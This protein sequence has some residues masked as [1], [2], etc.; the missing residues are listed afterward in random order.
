MIESLVVAVCLL[1][2]A[3][4]AAF[5]MAFVALSK[6]ELRGRARS[7]DKQAVIL[8]ALRNNPERTLSVLQIGI[9]L[10][11]AAAAAAGGAGASAS[12]APMLM[13]KFEFS[14]LAAELTSLGLVVV[15]I[16]FLSVVV[17][18]LVPKTLALRQPMKIALRGARWVLYVERAFKPL[19]RFFEWST[20]KIIAI[21]F[22]KAKQVEETDRTTIE[23]DNLSPIHQKFVLNMADIEKKKIND[24]FLPWSQVNFVHKSEAVN[25]VLQMVLRSGHT[26][27]PVLDDGKVVGV[28]HTKE[29]LSLKEGGGQN[30]LEL[31]RPVIRVHT[32]D[33]ALGVMRI[34]QE[35]RSH[36][37]IVYDK[38]K[39]EIFGI[40]TLEDILEEVVGDIYD[41]DDDGQIHKVYAA[42]IKSRIFSKP[43]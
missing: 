23:I 13:T 4:F 7:G 20:R 38:S 8:L 42:K 12:L 10:V 3:F 11:G 39:S 25:G 5:E 37:A 16:A 30:W 43:N 19:I 26:R 17:G 31:V 2:N 35:K 9:S 41:E 18:E 29:F 1:L 40:I 32:S 22:K 15:P 36:M 27:L 14:R 6:S 34:L 24:I 33:S 28:L 21:F